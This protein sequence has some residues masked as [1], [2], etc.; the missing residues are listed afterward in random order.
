MQLIGYGNPG[1]CDDGL[2]PAFAARVAAQN[3][4]GIVSPRR[5]GSSLSMP[6]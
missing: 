4:P 5:S 1:R 3:L 2:G 6:R